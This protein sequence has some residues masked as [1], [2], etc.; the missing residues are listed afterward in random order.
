MKLTKH[1]SKKL[2]YKKYLYKIEFELE[3]ASIFRAYYQ[4]ERLNNVVEKVDEY[5][6][7][8]ASSKKK[9]IQ[10]GFY[11]KSVVDHNTLDDCLDLRSAL[12]DLKEYNVRQ[13]GYNKLFVYLNDLDNLLS[14]VKNLKTVERIK[15]WEPD[16]ALLKNPDTDVLVSKY[17][18]E[19]THK[20]TINLW[21]VRKK[22]SSTLD[23]I[24]N[25]R[26]KIKI[27]DY[28]LEYASSQTGIYVRDEKVLMLLQ[29]TGDG[30]ITR[31]ERLVLPTQ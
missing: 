28:G 1:K 17:A 11:R 13:E 25:N 3:L 20:V 2:F 5:R 27:T 12:L 23:W 21:S 16:A 8:L 9:S 31:V 7:H 10:T 6:S 19:F 14:V 15:L 24:K 26:D 30:F 18:N 4:K 29:M 22:N